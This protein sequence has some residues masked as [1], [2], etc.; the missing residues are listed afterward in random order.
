MGENDA[1]KPVMSKKEEH[2]T[3][4][5]CL[6]RIRD[7][8]FTEYRESSTSSACKIFLNM[9]LEIIA[10]LF[11]DFFRYNFVFYKQLVYGQLNLISKSIKQLQFLTIPNIS[12]CLN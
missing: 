3:G 10:V 5:V 1:T 7:F 2:Y 6:Y 4:L 12:N 8:L 9:Y 11:Q